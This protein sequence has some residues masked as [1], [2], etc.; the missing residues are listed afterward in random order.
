MRVAR[1]RRERSRAGWRAPPGAA[2]AA[3]TARA[4]WVVAGADDGAG[5]EAMLPHP[6]S[7]RPIPAMT[8]AVFF[9][10]VASPP[11]RMEIRA[12]PTRK[13]GACA[14]PSRSDRPAAL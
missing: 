8:I 12:Y 14:R 5:R 3:G 10:N 11:Q 4:A 2:V 13:D 6:A 7:S 1:A 9:I